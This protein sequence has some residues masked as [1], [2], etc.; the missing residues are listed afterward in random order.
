MLGPTLLVAALATA[1]STADA[2][3]GDGPFSWRW[4]SAGPVRMRTETLLITPLRVKFQG[5]ENLNATMERIEMVLDLTC[6]GQRQDKLTELS[7]KVNNADLAGQA[8]ANDQERVEP[9]LNEYEQLLTGEGVTVEVEVR[10]DGH[11]R[12]LDLEGISKDR[13]RDQDIFENLRQLMRRALGPLGMQ[14]PKDGKNPGRPWQHKGM[15]LF[16]EMLNNNGTSGGAVYTYKVAGEAGGT[17]SIEASGEA[18]VASSL[19]R[20]AGLSSSLTLQSSGQY[21]FDTGNGTLAYAEVTVNGTTSTSHAGM[22]S[23]QAYV[24][25]SRLMRI[26]PDGSVEGPEGP[27]K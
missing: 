25:A 1:L 19:D 27:V 9:I 6:T 15:P 23:K 24:L 20:E 16:F 22:G 3:E 5:R 13:L 7:C 21:R 12:A 18:N 11:I 17:V 14:T 4:E 2:A 10:E 8:V 26:N